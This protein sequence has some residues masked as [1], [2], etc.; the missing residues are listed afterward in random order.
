MMTETGLEEG[1]GGEVVL[2]AVIVAAAEEGQGGQEVAL[3][4]VVEVEEV[5][6][7]GRQ[8]EEKVERR[9]NM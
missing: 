7:A 1:E 9:Q 6:Q 4:A 5:E 3:V 2:V 8:V